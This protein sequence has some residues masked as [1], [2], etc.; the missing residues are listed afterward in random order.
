MQLWNLIP[1]D[2]HIN[3]RLSEQ[4]DGNPTWNA[5]LE[6]LYV[7]SGSLNCMVRGTDRKSTRLNSSH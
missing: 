6:I 7:L 1:E 5:E 3:F 2:K 4:F